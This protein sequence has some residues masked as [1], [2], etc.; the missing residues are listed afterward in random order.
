MIFS[1][2]SSHSQIEMS[3]PSRLFTSK[4]RLWCR[5]PTVTNA[6]QFRAAHN[7]MEQYRRVS[8]GQRCNETPGGQRNYVP[9]IAGAIIFVGAFGIY[10]KKKWMS[11]VNAAVPTTS[12]LNNRAKYNFIADIVEQCA[13]SVV[14]IEIRDRRLVD[15]SSGKPMFASNGSGFIVNSN[16]LI[17]TNAHVVINKPHTAIVVTL[18]DGRSFD[19][20]IEAVDDTSDLATIRINCKGLP[21]L[22]LGSSKD[23]RAGEWVAALGSP[24]GLTNTITAGVVSSVQRP[25]KELGMR[26]KDFHEFHQFSTNFVNLKKKGYLFSSL[27]AKISITFKPMPQ[28][29]SATQAAH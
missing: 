28:S 9:V 17:L 4:L 13:P 5:H 21:I 2:D 27:Q 12:R 24:L 8:N 25:S 1:E 3:M 15:I 7:L 26:G 18:H 20:R 6:S 10:S 29:H 16:G 22:K 23:L 19:A 11:S 14:N